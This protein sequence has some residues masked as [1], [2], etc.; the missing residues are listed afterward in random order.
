MLLFAFEVPTGVVA[1]RFGRRISLFLG[2]V[3]FGLCFIIYAFTRSYLVLIA[4]QI[5]CA[6]AFSLISGADHALMYETACQSDADSAA[7]TGRMARYNAFGSAGMFT[8]FPIGS[9]F[10]ASGIAAYTT[11]LGMTFVASGTAI[12][13][14]GLIVLRVKEAQRPVATEHPIRT[15]I[16]G[17]TTL[18]RS[19]SLARLSVNTALVAAITFMMF[20]LYQAVLIG[21]SFPA[22]ALG[23]VSAAFN[24][25]GALVLFKMD[26]IRKKVP[27][28]ILLLVTSTATGIFYTAAGVF[29]V[30]PLALGA[31]FGVT[32]M[33]FMREPV[34]TTLINDS[35][36]SDIRATVLSGLSMLER[37]VIT[38]LYFAV[39]ILCDQS[40]PRAFVFLGLL[41]LAVTVLVPVRK[42][43]VRGVT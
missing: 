39:G 1:D 6:A 31:I 22:G 23:F 42:T 28:W 29:P 2:T 3:I 20:W 27:A 34:T 5:P 26:V 25:L 16:R 37:V 21:T 32:L 9:L 33:R 10:A 19:A 43:P 14:A 11:A 36:E 12:I 38:A 41:A 24:G 7:V 17:F 18:F 30:L 35:I 15:G 13:I 8:A 40:V 4:I